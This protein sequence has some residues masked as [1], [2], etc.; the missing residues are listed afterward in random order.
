MRKYKA[1]LFDVDGVLINSEPLVTEA[2]KRV[3]IEHGAPAQSTDFK[4]FTGMGADKFIGG[5]AEK[6]GIVYNTDM[7][8]RMHDIY[9]ELLGEQDNSFEGTLEM[10]HMLEARGYK[11]ALASSADNVKLTA[12]VNSVGLKTDRFVSVTSGSDVDRKKP[13]PD[14]YILSA[15]RTGVKP[16]D[17]LVVEDALSGI[18]SAKSAG[19]DCVGVTTSF[20]KASMLDA[21]ADYV[22]GIVGEILS[23]I[24]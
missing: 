18:K 5:V 21:G 14:I 6:Y 4:P 9:M 11:L 23:V 13:Y 7:K 12:N 10:I 8:D 24:E 19:M 20:D 17:C 22:V 1:I 15:Q 2:S 3:I 16:S